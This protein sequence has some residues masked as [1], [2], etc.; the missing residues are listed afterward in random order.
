MSETT[1]QTQPTDIFHWAN[2]A[3]RDKDQ[4]EIDL[5]LFTKG[6][7]VY[8]TKYDD[9]LKQQ[10]KVLFLYDMISGVQT[11]AAS[12]LVVRDLDQL[13]R[14]D[15]VIM[16]T[17]LEKVEH[18][19]EVIEQIA[20]GEEALETFNEQD[21]EFKKIKGMIARFT[22][23]K[24]E[25]QERKPFYVVKLLSGAQVMIG[26]TAW[27][28]RGNSFGQFEA[29]A[30]LKVTPDNQV[31]IAGDDI[32]VF[33]ESKF[34]RLFGY[35]AKKFAVADEKIREIEQH[36]KIK[37]PDGMTL[38]DLARDNKALVNKLQK[39]DPT[40]VTQDQLVNQADEME[41]ELMTDDAEQAI[42][43]VDAKDATK[44]VNLLSD[45]YMTSQMTGIKYLVKSKKPLDG[46]KS[47]EDPLVALAQRDI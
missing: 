26:S 25:G 19:Q 14:N 17:N 44:F 23:P 6:F 41:L 8:A 3:D 24:R 28:F 40:L 1:E 5:Y 32:F 42:L 2:G 4:L 7:T 43:L 11:G 45:D 16:H 46:E 35:S 12:G 39:V 18:A 21:H 20:F 37:L 9:K 30:G 47:D 34:E 38:G 29:E 10:L 27:V 22:S 33:S 31:M 15:N 36:F 13:D